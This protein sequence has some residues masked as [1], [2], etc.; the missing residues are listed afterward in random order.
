MTEH[1]IIL[2]ACLAVIVVLA[3]LTY[4]SS[5]NQAAASAA[6][7]EACRTLNHILASNRS[8]EA[9]LEQHRRVLYD[10]H[11]RI[12]AVSKGLEKPTS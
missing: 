9:A 8:I 4:V 6:V 11:K 3:V 2:L 1:T 12:Y 5:R 10:A 7:C